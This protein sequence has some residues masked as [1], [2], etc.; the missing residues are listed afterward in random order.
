M[1]LRWHPALPHPTSI[2][3]PVTHPTKCHTPHNATT[4][5]ACR[6]LYMCLQKTQE[7]QQRLYHALK[8]EYNSQVCVSGGE[9]E[10]RSEGGERT[11]VRLGALLSISLLV[12]VKIEMKIVALAIM[13][14]GMMSAVDIGLPCLAV[15][16]A[17]E[18]SC[19]C[20]RACSLGCRAWRSA[21]RWKKLMVADERAQ[22]DCARRATLSGARDAVDI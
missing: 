1:G 21:V 9:G 3:L 12:A 22:L 2:S 19:G 14:P 16:G 20:G 5:T 18:K 15:C 4:H 17:V 8:Q 10:L 13:T 11:V 6:W 7:E